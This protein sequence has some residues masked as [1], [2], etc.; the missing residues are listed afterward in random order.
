MSLLKFSFKIISAFIVY[1]NFLKW[2]VENVKLIKPNVLNMKYINKTI[3][4]NNHALKKPSK[5]P[6]FYTFYDSISA[7]K[8]FRASSK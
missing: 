7:N 4:L 8:S 3:D 1:K 6:C 2:L 5:K